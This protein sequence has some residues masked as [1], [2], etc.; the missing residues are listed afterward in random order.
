MQRAP[1]SAGDSQ[2]AVTHRSGDRGAS[3]TCGWLSRYLPVCVV[4]LAH[5]LLD[6]VVLSAVLFGQLRSPPV[7]VN[8]PSWIKWALLYLDEIR[9]VFGHNRGLIDTSLPALCLATSQVGLLAAWIWVGRGPAV[10][11][12]LVGG[13]GI[14]L[15]ACALPFVHGWA[16]SVS[17]SG[18]LF[19][20]Q[21]LTVFGLLIILP[22]SRLG[23]EPERHSQWTNPRPRA[24][25]QYTL[26]ELLL[27]MTIAGAL[28]GI[29]DRW[30]LLEGAACAVTT[31]AALA[32]TGP[33]RW[34]FRFALAVIIP[35]MVGYAL[36]RFFDSQHRWWGPG[37]HLPG[38]WAF[39][40]YYL[41]YL[42][43]ML[44]HAA[45]IVAAV[46]TRRMVNAVVRNR[47]PRDEGRVLS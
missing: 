27:A 14:W 46:L 29:R 35:T 17:Q 30:I 23:L 28:L 37:S 39:A 40:N 5:L 47:P 31:V 16:F 9:L 4:L 32:A 42:A 43:W 13:A 41:A 21:S 6:V 33:R 15:W 7:A 24:K 19:A 44:I 34:S 20:A 8:E 12:W 36:M 10:W 45:C 18:T 38:H 2:R 3:F 11:R 26:G 25:W 1:T 22:R